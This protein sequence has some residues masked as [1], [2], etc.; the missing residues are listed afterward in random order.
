MSKRTEDTSLRTSV[1]SLSY[2]A[3][4]ILGLLPRSLFKAD[5][6]SNKV[7]MWALG[8]LVHETLTSE[9]PFLEKPSDNESLDTGLVDITSPLR[10]D[11]NLLLQFCLGKAVLP[12]ERLQEV[13]VSE[14]GVDFLKRLLVADPSCRNSA[15][16]ALDHSWVKVL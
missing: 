3:P 6:Y 12:T 9:I 8:C 10:A 1:V 2:A 5:V 4:E 16:E 13:G 11:L 7:D 14:D 15:A